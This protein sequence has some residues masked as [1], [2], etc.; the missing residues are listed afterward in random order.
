MGDF[1]WVPFG[2]KKDYFYI[3]L[4]FLNVYNFQ[5]AHIGSYALVTLLFGGLL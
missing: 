2:M 5:Y 4:L 3:I 1:S